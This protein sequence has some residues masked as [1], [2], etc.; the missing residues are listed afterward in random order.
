MSI[1]FRNILSASLISAACLASF[2]ACAGGMI[3]GSTR[4][5]Y[6]AGKKQVS[7]DIHN[8]STRSSFMVQS[9]V[10]SPDGKKTNDF[11]ITPPLY[12]SGPENENTLRIIYVGQPVRKDQETLYYFNSKA[13]PSLDKEKIEGQNILLLAATTRIKL[14]MRPD[15]LSPSVDQ[16]QNLLTFHG[17]G[18]KITVDNPSPYYITLAAMKFADKNLPDTMVPPH[19][20][21]VIPVQGLASGTLRYRTINDYGAVT[22]EHN[23]VITSG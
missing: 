6:P 2:T 14:F 21:T 5:I 12:V 9:W 1:L 20:N 13:I 7:M 15:G 17:Q 16:A 4:V 11:I 10:E 8:T 3:L 18:N 23:T 22:I 19:G